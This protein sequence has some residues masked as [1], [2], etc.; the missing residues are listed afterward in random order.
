MA[1]DGPAKQ[2]AR[3]SVKMIL[4]KLNQDS[5]V[6]YNKGELDQWGILHKMSKTWL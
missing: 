5:L 4:T 1:A 2:R 3:E 6:L